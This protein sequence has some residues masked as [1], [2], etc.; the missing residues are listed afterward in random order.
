MADYAGHA[1][2]DRTQVQQPNPIFHLCENQRSFAATLILL[3]RLQGV[4][5]KGGAA[6]LA[7]PGTE[8]T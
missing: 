2:G 5:S 4:L 3:L 6:S 8:S 7:A 1:A